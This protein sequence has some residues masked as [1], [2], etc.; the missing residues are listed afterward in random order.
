[1]PTYDPAEF[2]PDRPAEELLRAMCISE[3]IHEVHAVL[4]LLPMGL[5]AVFGAW[6]VFAVTSLAACAF[7]LGFAVMQRFNR[8]RVIRL[9]ARRGDE[10]KPPKSE[11]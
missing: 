3:V 4:S 2:R 9:A 1:M 5:G 10:K 11:K 7:D 6:P 8:P